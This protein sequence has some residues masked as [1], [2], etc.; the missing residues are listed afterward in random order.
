MS[1][2]TVVGLR[3]STQAGAVPTT[4]QISEGELAF[5]IPDRKIFARFGPHV[6]DITDRYSQQQIDD[7]LS[8]KANVDDLKAVA[9]SGSYNDLINKP[10]LGTAAAQ[11]TDAFDPSGAAASAVNAHA[12]APDPHSQYV[13]KETGKGL[14]AEDYT[15]SEKGKLAS[16]EAGAQVNPSIIDALT[17]DVADQP[18]SANQGR[19]LKGLIDTIN[20]LLQSDDG[21]LDELQEIVDYIKLNRNELDSLSI[22]SIA[23]LSDA[24]DGKQPLNSVL[25]NTTASFTSAL[26]SKLSGIESGA[27]A[28]QT[29]SDIDSLG[30]NADTL[31]GKHANEFDAAGSANN[32][33][34]AHNEADDPHE[35]YVQKETGKGLSDR[36]YTQTEK[37]KL[38]A[39][40]TMANRAVYIS[41]QPPDDA[42]GQDGDI[43]LQHW[44]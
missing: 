44:S 19:A 18:L 14:S 42:V 40:G 10:T 25:T 33:V 7:A 29:K 22:V 21:A 31:D 23:G 3:I 26:L 8:G 36:N 1:Y 5:N 6:D 12:S 11:N 2:Q 9:T 38:A 15:T 16:V 13:Q 37:A 43:W 20:T 27:T 34:N 17:S 39:V 28:D 24:L 35:Q 4:A 41:D 32:A 30:V